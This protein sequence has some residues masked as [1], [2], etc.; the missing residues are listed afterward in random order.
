LKQ[1]IPLWVG[2]LDN[3]ARLDLNAIID[4]F[5]WTTVNFGEDNNS[6]WS[7]WYYERI[8]FD[9]FDCITLCRRYFS[10]H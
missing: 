6:I 10:D 8:S 5:N 9:Q 3:G 2:G 4:S 1:V 7:I